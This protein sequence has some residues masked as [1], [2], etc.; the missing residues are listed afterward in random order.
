MS[1]FL[2]VKPMKQAKSEIAATKVKAQTVY[3]DKL[4]YMNLEL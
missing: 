3:E 4:C 1:Y 2:F